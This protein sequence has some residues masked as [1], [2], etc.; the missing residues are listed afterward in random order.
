M[1]NFSWAAVALGAG[2]VRFGADTR[3]HMKRA[4]SV[5]A[6]GAFFVALSVS[7]GHADV[8]TNYKATFSSGTGDNLLTAEASIQIDLTT[9][10][11]T[12][13]VTDDNANPRSTGNLVSGIQLVFSNA[14][15]SPSSFSGTGTLVNLTQGTCSMGTCTYTA[16]PTGS[17]NLNEWK[18]TTTGST[19]QLT[20][21]GGGNQTQLIIGKGPYTNGNPSL[22]N[23]QPYVQTTANFGVTLAGLIDGTG[24]VPE[25]TLS[26]VNFNF[27][28]TQFTW[29]AALVT[30]VG[31]TAPV[32][33]PIFGGGLP[34]LIAACAGLVAFARRRRLRF[35]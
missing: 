30:P 25:T 19:L 7:A 14:V 32:P 15:H 3:T 1:K 4:I 33:G 22:G 2:L 9:G 18:D 13:A 34:G 5:I 10:A 12:V 29:E 28:T 23:D 11:V 20:A 16:A 26:G 35:A 31:G 6:M 8:V 21:L 17:T 27:S 24:L